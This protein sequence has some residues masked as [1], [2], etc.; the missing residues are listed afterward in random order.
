MRARTSILLEALLREAALKSSSVPSLHATLT[1]VICMSSSPAP[2]PLALTVTTDDE[3][4]ELR[5][6]RPREEDPLQVPRVLFAWWRGRKTAGLDE[7]V[8]IVTAA[9][10]RAAISLNPLL[11]TIYFTGEETRTGAINCDDDEEHRLLYCDCTFCS[12]AA[13]DTVNL[14]VI[15]KTV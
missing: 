13:K 12:F 6:T 4:E 15:I 8:V 9:R 10:V 11:L 7:M 1:K 3:R 14:Q 5:G 2:P